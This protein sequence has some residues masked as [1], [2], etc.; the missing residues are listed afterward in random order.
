MCRKCESTFSMN[1]GENTG[2][3]LI[4]ISFFWRFWS[5]RLPCSCYKTW[6]QTRQQLDLTSP[7]TLS[8]WPCTKAAQRAAK[9]PNS[10]QYLKSQGRHFLNN[11]ASA[12]LITWAT[13][14]PGSQGACEHTAKRELWVQSFPLIVPKHGLAWLMQRAEGSKGFCWH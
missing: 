12:D 3:V 14:L 10:L 7:L 6:W 5:I 13:K 4:I 11:F 2:L 1:L 8:D 9:F